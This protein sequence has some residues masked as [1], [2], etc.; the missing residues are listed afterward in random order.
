MSKRQMQTKEEATRGV[1]KLHRRHRIRPELRLVGGRDPV[2]EVDFGQL[3]LRT[4]CFFEFG[5]FRFRPL[6]DIL[7]MGSCIRDPT[8]PTSWTI[9]FSSA[10]ISSFR[11]DDRKTDV[12]ATNATQTEGKDCSLCYI[13]GPMPS[14][15][16]GVGPAVPKKYKGL[17]VL[18]GDVV[19][20]DSGSYAVFTEQ[21]LSASK[22]DGRKSSGNFSQTT[23][24]RWTSKRRSIRLHP[25][26]H[27][28]LSD[29]V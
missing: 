25:S 7:T 10:A 4:I 2:V 22:N 19:K 26:Q 17:V 14:Q 8:R 23:W 9:L 20:D 18:R 27:G 6:A 15:E 13:D 21:G 3:R 1:A 5:Q 28:R 12:K 11:I 29:T 16:L 24:S